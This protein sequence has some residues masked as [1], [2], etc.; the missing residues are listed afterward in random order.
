MILRNCLLAG[1]IL[2]PVACATADEPRSSL[3]DAVV[4]SAGVAL[5]THSRNTVDNA[6]VIQPAEELR[7]GSA[8]GPS[9]TQFAFIG[10][11]LED[12]DGT[13][14]L[15]DARNYRVSVFGHDGSFIRWFGR[16]GS[17]PGEFSQSTGM[18]LFGDTL[19]VLEI[20]RMHAFDRNGNLL[21]TQ[22]TETGR[23]RR[24]VSGPV[25]TTAGVL[26]LQHER[27][28]RQGQK[29]GPFRDSV[30][31]SSYDPATAQVGPAIRSFPGPEFWLYG[32]AGWYMSPLFHPEP[33]LALAA[34]GHIYFSAGDAY[35]I[36][37]HDRTGTLVRRVRADVERIPV[38]DE[39]LREYIQRELSETGG[40]GEGV[41]FRKTFE[42]EAEGLGHAEFRPVVG[43]IMVARDGS[44][45]VERL[46][47][48]DEPFESG[49][50]A[51]WDLIDADGRI[52]G[53]VPLGARVTPRYFTGTHLYAVARDDDD[54]QYLVRYRLR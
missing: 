38:T 51:T 27:V 46:D 18:A 14:W 7:L 28:D 23:V 40:G 6:P 9:H 16:R 49:D 45:L 30:S 37:V 17:G 34:N 50:D 39:D 54:V 24:F 13:I 43:R 12:R 32:A 21:H 19:L 31:V 41:E 4:D 26:V 33:S 15:Y 8:D 36:D 35:A 53:R 42:Q 22:L 47:L 1:A 48:D 10:S 2:S 52:A 20:N 5:V 3:A 11:V 25:G 44:L 29:G